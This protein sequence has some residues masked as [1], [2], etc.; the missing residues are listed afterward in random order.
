VQYAR[1]RTAY[2]KPINKLQGV[3]FDLADMATQVEV[4]H[5]FVMHVARMQAAGLSCE[6]EASMAKRFA[7]EMAERVCSDA[8]QV[9]GGYG[10]IAGVPVERYYRDARVTKIYEGTS[11]IQK[12]I[13]SRSLL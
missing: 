9:H 11:H 3:G 10:Y 6:T 13:I 7:S 8:L 4:A 12:V 2:G 1:E 5:Q